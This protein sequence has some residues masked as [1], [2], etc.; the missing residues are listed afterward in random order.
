MVILLVA[1]LYESLSAILREEGRQMVVQNRVLSRM[2]G[3]KREE[4]QE[5]GE[6]HPK[7]SFAI[8]ALY[9]N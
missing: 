6:K 8:C 2:F 5:T 9:H 3:P 4:G 1:Y 7:K